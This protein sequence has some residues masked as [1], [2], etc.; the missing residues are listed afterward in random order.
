MKHKK[1]KNH[2]KII[3]I[4]ILIL[5]FQVKVSA[6]TNYESYTLP[7]LMAEIKMIFL[8]STTYYKE[9]NENQKMHYNGFYKVT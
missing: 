3:T 6:Q 2:E 1:E 9:L 7:Q 4:L 5:G 8:G